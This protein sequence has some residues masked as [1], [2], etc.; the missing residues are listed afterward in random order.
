MLA[1]KFALPNGLIRP[2]KMLFNI[3]YLRYFQRNNNK[4]KNNNVILVILFD[5]VFRNE[6][7]VG[8]ASSHIYDFGSKVDTKQFRSK[9]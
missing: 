3:A 4:D 5:F 7:L 9:K 8:S 2:L 6:S 1:I